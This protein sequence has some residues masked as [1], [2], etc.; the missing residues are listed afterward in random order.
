MQKIRNYNLDDV[1]V[2]AN[3]WGNVEKRNVE[4]KCCNV[5]LGCVL[6]VI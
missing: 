4:R 1:D 2:A 6:Y 5:V 3:M